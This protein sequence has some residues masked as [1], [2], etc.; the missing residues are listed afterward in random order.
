METFKASHWALLDLQYEYLD[1]G[2]KFTATTDVPCHLYCRMTKTPPR[3]HVLPSAQRG[4]Y[5]TGDVRFCFVVYEDNDQEEAGDTLTHTWFKHPWPYCET[6]WFYFVGE[7]SGVPVVSETAIFTFHFPAPPP[8]PPPLVNSTLYPAADADLHQLF[9]S[10]PEPTTHWDKVRHQ[11]DGKFVWWD[12]S[13][14]RYDTYKLTYPPL[15]APH[16][17]IA[18][19]TVRLR[20]FR[21]NWSAKHAVLF[22]TH[23]VFWESD[24]WQHAA[25]SW[26]W[27]AYDFP[28]NPVT[29]KS[30]TYAE[31]TE[32]V[33]GVGMYDSGMPSGIYCDALEVL[34]T[35]VPLSQLWQ[36]PTN[37]T[38]GSG[39]AGE[40]KVYDE[41]LETMATV[42]VPFQSWSN[43]L[44]LT[45]Y[46]LVCVGVRFFADKST[47]G[48]LNRV[49][50]DIFYAGDWHTVVADGEYTTLAW[51]EY[52]FAK[53]RV[54]KARVAF[55]N[56]SGSTAKPAHFREFDF[57]SDIKE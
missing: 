9:A 20:L 12:R 54:S 27:E 41:D 34:I 43:W 1:D 21:K 48:S 10:I 14:N 45:I 2:W 40:T 37:F 33:A 46:E 36:S 4:T 28:E 38:A 11:D 49:K 55:W 52:T 31:M 18:K 25:S 47:D 15:W 24:F 39:W 17:K 57:K 42:G 44:E 35:W 53:H 3:K 32:L 7:I 51:N 30:W 56:S 16:H 8:D 29:L 23:G 5:W 26:T 13:F 19:I 22:V 6:R 50:I